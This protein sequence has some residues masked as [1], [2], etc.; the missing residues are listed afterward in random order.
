MHGTPTDEARHINRGQSKQRWV[1]L[2]LTLQAVCGGFGAGTGSKRILVGPG[3]RI[4]G[5]REL[6]SKSPNKPAQIVADHNAPNPSGLR[7][8]KSRPQTEGLRDGCRHV[9]TGEAGVDRGTVIEDEPCNLG[10]VAAGAR[11]GNLSS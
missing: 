6:L 7:M 4:E 9:C 1:Y 3:G 10:R 5:K 2:A 11:R 8:A